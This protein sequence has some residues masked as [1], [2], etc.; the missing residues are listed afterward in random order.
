MYSDYLKNAPLALS[1]EKAELIIQDMYNSVVND[2]NEDVKDLLQDFMRN[3]GEYAKIRYGWCRLS[4]EERVSSDAGRTAVHNLLLGTYT[5]LHR[6]LV[7]DGVEHKW[8]AELPYD[9]TAEDEWKLRK[10][11]GDLACYMVL[12]DSLSAR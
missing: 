5:V 8:Y 1:A 2:P 10:A 7:Q 11:V 12:F 4:Q 9:Q 6:A 3:A